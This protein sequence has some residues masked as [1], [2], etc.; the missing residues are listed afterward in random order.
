METGI[1]EMP[2]L[3]AEHVVRDFVRQSPMLLVLIALAAVFTVSVDNFVSYANFANMARLF[4]PLLILAIG[5]TVVFIAGGIDLSVGSTASM[6]SVIC[7]LVIQ[8]T[9]IMALGF[10]AGIA[11]GLLIGAI[12]GVVIAI[13]RLPALVFT[14]AMLLTVRAVALLITGGYSVGKLPLSVLAFGRGSLFAVPNLLWIALGVL[15]VSGIFLARSMRGREIY[16]VGTSERAATFNALRVTSTK[17]FAYLICGGCA[18]LAGVTIVTRLGSGGPVVGDN[19]LLTGIAAVVLGGTSIHGGE[20]TVF[21]TLIG[22]LIVVLLEK[23]L[24]LFGLSFYDQAIVMGAV[25]LAGASFSAWMH[26]KQST[27]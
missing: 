17:F 1:A 20:G 26:R 25:I 27:R 21:K 5:M 11:T 7:A 6:A 22:T 14:L 8:Q 24:N 4:A 2:K 10:A 3:G 18:G 23:G 12:N 15:I 19:L 16:L 9:G 13:F